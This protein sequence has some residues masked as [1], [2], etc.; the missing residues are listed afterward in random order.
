M[1]RANS[2]PVSLLPL[3]D[4]KSPEFGVCRLVQLRWLRLEYTCDYSFIFIFIF[5]QRVHWIAIID[6]SITIKYLF[7]NVKIDL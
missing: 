2:S 7:P 4:K 1:N 5:I 6:A 3:P